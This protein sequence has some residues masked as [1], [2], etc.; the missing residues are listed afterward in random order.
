MT[1]PS[2]TNIL[3]G[4]YPYQHGVR[5]NSGFR[6]DPRFD[7]AA[8]RLAARG[9][10]AGAFV[11][12]F[13]LDSRYGLTRGFD[14]YN[15]LYRH[16]DEPREFEIPQSRADEVVR[17]ALAWWQKQAGRPRF[18]W[19]HVYDPH[20]PYDPPEEYAKKFPDDPYLGEVAFADASLAPLLDAI[21][22]T[23]PSPLLVVTGDHGEAR[24]DHGE[25]TH[26]LFAYE[27]TLHIPL[28]IWCPDLVPPGRDE[29]SARH[30]DI[31]PTM[32]WAVGAA[33]DPAL[34]GTSLGKSAPEV[35]ESYFESLGPSFNRG[36]APLRGI[37][38]DRDKYID[39]PIQELYD[40]RPDPGEKNNL[41]GTDSGTFRKLRK[42]LLEI[43]SGPTTRG[44]VGEDEASKLRS[45]GYLSGQSAA[46][47]HYGPEDDPKSLIAVDA[48][49]HQT[50]MLY[51]TGHHDEAIAVA[52]KIVASNPRMK[53]G[54][55]H[56]GFL[57][58]EKG[59]I[60]GAI[61]VFEQASANGAGGE[62]IDRR[63]AMLLCE[64]G[65]PKEAVTLLTPYR[66]AVDTETLNALGIALSDAGKGP[67]GL[68]LFQHALTINPRDTLA[69]Q[70]LGIGMLKMDRAAEAQEYLQKALAVHERNPR[71]WNALGVA[72][73]QLDQPA[74][75]LEAWAECLK[76]NPKQYDALYNTA[77]VAC[78][79]GDRSR[80][81]DAMQ[82]FVETA[83][84]AQYGKDIAQVR[85]ALAALDRGQPTSKEN[86]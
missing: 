79:I 40:L 22:Q 52:R 61:R 16:M 38:R 35:A 17:T 20:A 13:P 75:A 66:E 49:L 73:M 68:E 24:G 2:H 34:P 7:T 29:R 31:L 11:A 69:L 36:W 50:V 26:G 70:N 67:E 1:L 19:V 3:T 86:P 80:A 58:Q 74:R 8:T 45:L 85:A 77:L 25:L 71:A 76:Y 32:L 65:D 51:E 5:D 44:S 15:E 60:R 59:D 84:P 28:F 46:K 42:A 23:K 57:L 21:K 12:A 39:L 55:E 4:L 9:F 62:T 56:L 53:A 37:L 41:A 83:P 27:A 43:P 48:Q 47:T 63:R 54:Y 82:R 72:R 33:K 64:A 10:A 6:L 14:P 81:R 78:K 30:V 18:L